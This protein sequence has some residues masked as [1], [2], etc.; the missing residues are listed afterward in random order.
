M[1]DISSTD[2]TPT[3]ISAITPPVE[4]DIEGLALFTVDNKKYLIASSQGNNSYAIYHIHE[5]SP[6]TL[7]LMGLVE[8]AA[9]RTKQ[10]DGV[11]ETDG[12][13]ATNADLGGAFTEGLWV[14][15]D[16][17]NVMPSQ[18]QNFKL[19]AGSALKDAIRELVEPQD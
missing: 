10:I 18:N 13:E 2:N 6:K 8:I 7:T 5:E 17:R 9:D 1:L 12:L 19:V 3:F 16:G 11:S 4:A 14:V 15:Q